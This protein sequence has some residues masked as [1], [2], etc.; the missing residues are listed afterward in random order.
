MKKLM[1][2]ALAAV[3]ALLALPSFASANPVHVSATGNFTVHGGPSKLERTDG[4]FTHGT[5]VTGT[6]SFENTTTGTVE[7]TFH[8]VTS[9]SAGGSCAS[10]GQPAGTV[11]TTK[12]PFHL[13]TLNSGAPGILITALNNHFATFRCGPFQVQVAVNGNGIIGTITSPG[14]GGTSNKANV[15]FKPSSAGHQGHNSVTGV[16]YGLTSTIFSTSP[17]S[18]DANATITFP[19]NRTVTCT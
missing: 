1:L 18:M 14:C 7:L 19:A 10:T 15:S 17:S 9:D 13:V 16:T 5:T 4:N 12:L 6:G 2:L 11:K 3:C 8:G